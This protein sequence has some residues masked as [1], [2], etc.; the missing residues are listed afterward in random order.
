MAYEVASQNL[1]TSK[2]SMKRAAISDFCISHIYRVNSSIST[3]RFKALKI[4][5]ISAVEGLYGNATYSQFPGD[6]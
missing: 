6:L 2:L 1:V 5:G 3:S 4:A